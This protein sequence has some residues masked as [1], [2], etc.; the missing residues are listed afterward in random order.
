MRALFNLPSILIYARMTM[1]GRL[2][3]DAA[4]SA[5]RLCAY[6]PLYL[7]MCAAEKRR[8]EPGL[9]SLSTRTRTLA[10]ADGINA[11]VEIYK[12]VSLL[13]TDMVSVR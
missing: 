5:G 4:R 2:G 7:Q 9:I 1:R 6:E 8:S 13:G 10:Q 11:R 3:G 12:Y